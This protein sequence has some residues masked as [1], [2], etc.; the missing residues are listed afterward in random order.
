VIRI[1][2]STAKGT[3]SDDGFAWYREFVTPNTVSSRMR[4]GGR[5]VRGDEFVIHPEIPLIAKLF[6]NVPDTKIWLTN[7]APGGNLGQI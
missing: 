5:S 7:P 6:V 3:R 2:T 1:V 4:M